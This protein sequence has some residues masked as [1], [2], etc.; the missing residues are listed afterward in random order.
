MPEITITGDGTAQGVWAMLDIVEW[1][2]KGE[3]VGIKGH[4]HYEEEYVREQGEWRIRRL[5]LTRL[6]RDPLPGGLP[7]DVFDE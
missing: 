1:P 3:P 6:R 5:R 2:S 7:P 4:G